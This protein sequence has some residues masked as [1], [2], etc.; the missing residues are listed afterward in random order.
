[1][2][3]GELRAADKSGRDWAK[4]TPKE[5]ERILQSR[6][7]GFP[8]GYED[9]LAD[10]FRRISRGEEESAVPDSNPPAATE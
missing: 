4:L 6:D 9:V 2:K 3:E 5:R 8:P 10:Y 7:E 1:M